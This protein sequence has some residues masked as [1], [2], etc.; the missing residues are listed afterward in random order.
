[1]RDWCLQRLLTWP[2][3]HESRQLDTAAGMSNVV[4][5]GAGPTQVVLVPG[6]NSSAA[7]CLPLV[8][9][10]AEQW[11][12]SVL[13]LPGQPGLSA[14]HRPATGRITWYARW[15]GE[16]LDAIAPGPTIVL[17]HSLGGAI[18]LACHSPRIAARVLVS[19]GGLTR[20]QLPARLLGATV[21]WMLR[22]TE[23]RSAA[24]LRLMLA[25]NHEPAGDLVE[26]MTLVASACHSSLAPNPLPAAVL[27]SRRT[28][29]MVIAAGTHDV[30]LPPRRLQ[31]VATSLLDQQVRCLPDAGHMSLDEQPETIAALVGD[32]SQRLAQ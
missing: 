17:G 22:P 23:A 21:R 25:P 31:P 30:F 16:V 14:G 9:M 24:L 13:D 2:V 3:A 29:P 18:A 6:T 4:T 28:N 12:T 19:P 5:A 8:G 20:L 27:R 32:I 26:W 11:T 10:L 1:M 7:T 15:L